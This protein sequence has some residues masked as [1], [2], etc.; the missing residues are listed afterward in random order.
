MTSAP[1]PR[2]L[3]ARLGAAF[4]AL[5]GLA[6]LAAPWLTAYAP[7]AQL[8]PVALAWQPPSAAHWLGTDS[9]SRDVWSRLLF[10]ARATMGIALLA[11]TVSLTLGTLVGA[12]AALAPRW[13]DA[14]LMRATDALLAIPRLLLLL[15]VVAG[16]GT[17]EVAPLAILL[18][19]TGWMTTARVVRQESGRLLATPHLEGARALGVPSGRLLT[20]HLLPSL[21]PTLAV[22]ATAAF[23]AAVPLESG[24]SYLGLGVRTP[25]PSWGNLLADAESQPLAHWWVIVFPTLAIAGTVLAANALTSALERRWRR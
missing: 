11:V 15:L 6:A 10:G 22:A 23:A 17:L 13:L 18:G 3:G 25:L 16:A 1:R 14:L 5:V 9:Y 24:L 8:D 19:A 4:L 20:R 21:L 2:E 12:L 7:T